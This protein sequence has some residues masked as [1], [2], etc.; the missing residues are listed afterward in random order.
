VAVAL[1]TFTVFLCNHPG[2]KSKG[3]FCFSKKPFKNITINFLIVMGFL[4]IFRPTQKQYNLRA[5]TSLKSL[6]AK[7]ILLT[8]RPYLLLTFK[9]SSILVFTQI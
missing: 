5:K 6:A 2:Q 8:E 1:N 9:L 7:A 3:P 4:Y